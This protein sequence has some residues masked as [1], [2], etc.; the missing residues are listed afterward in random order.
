MP[1]SFGLG[2]GLGAVL[3][4]MQRNA[5]SGSWEMREG[6]QGLSFSQVET[7]LLL[8]LSSWSPGFASSALLSISQ[9]S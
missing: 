5:V 8:S 9:S 1:R 6:T 2:R 3:L 4:D 7:V